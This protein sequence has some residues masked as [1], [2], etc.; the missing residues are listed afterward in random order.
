MVQHTGIAD[1]ASASLVVGSFTGPATMSTAMTTTRSDVSAI[2][3]RFYIPTGAPTATTGYTGY[4]MDSSTGGNVPNRTLQTQNFGT[5][6]NDVW[7][8]VTFPSSTLLT[9][10][11]I[12]WFSVFY[13]NAI[14]DQLARFVTAQPFWDT[15]GCT[16][17]ADGNASA[18]FNGSYNFSATNPTFPNA[19][20]GGIWLGMD[21]IIDAPDLAVSASP[22][23]RTLG[24]T[25][26][27]TLGGDKSGPFDWW[28]PQDN[29]IAPP[30]APSSMVTWANAVSNLNNAPAKILTLGNSIGEGQ[31]SSTKAK[32]WQDLLLNAIRTYYPTNSSLG[33]SVGGE[34]FKPAQYAVYGTSNTW[35]RAEEAT[36]TGTWSGQ[37][38]LGLGG[39]GIRM[40]AASTA[41]WTVNGDNAEIWWKA[42]GGTFSWKV[43]GGSTTNINTSGVGGTSQANLTSISLGALGSHTIVLTWVSG[44]C[45][46]EGIN[47]FNTDKDQGIHLYDACRTGAYTYTFIGTPM[48]TELFPLVAPDLVLIELVGANNYLNAT[49]S[50]ASAAADV[51]TQLNMLD[52]LGKKPSVVIIIPFGWAATNPNGLGNNWGQ[53]E[54]AML[55]LTYSSGLTFLDLYQ[56]WGLATAGGKWDPDAIHNSDLGH[57]MISDLLLPMISYSQPAVG[58]PNTV[59]PT[60]IVDAETVGNV[61]VSVVPIITPASIVDTES[62]GNITLSTTAT[63]SPIGIISSE[64]V[65]NVGISQTQTVSPTG[66]QDIESVGNIAV[67]AGAVTV[68]PTGIS[69]FEIEGI[70]TAYLGS[71]PQP[72][73]VNQTVGSGISAANQNITC[74]ATIGNYLVLIYARSGGLATGIVTSVTDTGGNTWSGSAITRGAVSGVS[75]SRIEVWT[76][77][78]TASPGT[79]TV[80]SATAQTNSWNINEWS[81][82]VS[83]T[84][85]D[86]T[87]PDN[88]GDA[89][90]TT[91]P[92]PPINTRNPNDLIIAASHFSQTTTSG[93]TSGFTPLNN[94]DDA[95]VGSGRAAYAVFGSYGTYNAQWT[96]G[97]ARA[98][99]VVTFALEVVSISSQTISPTGIVD[100]DS[101]GNIAV[102]VGDVTVSPVGI[103]DSES[104]GNISA[105]VSANTISPFGIVDSESVGTAN[106]TPGAVTVSP[107]GI[108]DIE[109]VGNIGISQTVTPFGIP[110]PSTVGN[111]STTVIVAVNPVGIVDAESVGNATLTTNVTVSTTGIVSNESVGNVSISQIVLTI[112]PTGIIDTE[113]VG[114]VS[115]TTGA[116]TVSP[117]GIID[118][119]S[120]GNVTVLQAQQILP[121]GIVDGSS[122]GNPTIT[123]G[124]VTVSPIGIVS[125]Q[126][127]GSAT[128]AQSLAATGI[129]TDSNVGNVSVTVSAVQVNPVGIVDNESVGN[130]SITTGS[131]TVTAFGIKSTDSVGSATISIGSITVS[132]V[133]IPSVEKL[134]NVTVTTGPVTVSATGIPSAQTVGNLAV[135]LVQTVNAYGIASSEKFGKVSITVITLFPSYTIGNMESKWNIGSIESKWTVK[136]SESKWNIPN[137]ESR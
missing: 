96:L 130:V 64:T 128:V 40:T 93:L 111:I 13:P 79:I 106:V 62:V 51:Q 26:G 47:V 121:V 57:K 132:P 31:G 76:A 50:P 15:S 8:S 39:R 88:S 123:T 38:T 125:A 11:K 29:A 66:I 41:T 75:N 78:L 68:S 70:P 113:S 114:N 12:Y 87:S 102:T 116:V 4:L 94:F 35:G 91:I 27:G 80:N 136:P 56:L 36:M 48:V 22:A 52:G 134:G 49:S 67:T 107:T 60:G 115:I 73:L 9:A 17:I 110:S 112:S 54:S 90:S 46:I 124:A 120:V 72:T 109:T 65:S 30:A 92:T 119:E 7:M 63:V 10:G 81:G 98:A 122:V 45:D 133:G 89:L 42:G 24:F 2:G 44:T 105:S 6:S 71:I 108:Q 43:D 28:H 58:S 33:G 61:T 135:L 101:V 129:P 23:L 99:G 21:P 118:T 95:A 82:I 32:R 84:P 18:P 1:S 85:I 100:V 86:V 131:V 103:V 5:V 104:V 74:A 69:S 127:V 55:G 34:G 59:S 117:V 53:F 16:L 14:P 25:P 3:V 97:V 20:N 19:G 83:A 137:V 126:S 37:A 77:R